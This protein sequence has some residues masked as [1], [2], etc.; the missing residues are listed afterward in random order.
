MFKI[1]IPKE[2]YD[3]FMFSQHLTKIIHNFVENCGGFVMEP[4]AWGEVFYAELQSKNPNN[5]N[6][7][8]AR[9]LSKVFAVLCHTFYFA[10]KKNANM[11]I[12]FVS[13]CIWEK[14]MLG[15]KTVKVST[16]RLKEM[17]L[18]EYWNWYKK[19][20]KRTRHTA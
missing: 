11:E 4:I 5:Q 9:N 7:E 1:G 8:V 12:F 10:K 20:D 19:S 17:G 16:E 15:R 3:K 2:L 14:H 18:I 6:R 13:P